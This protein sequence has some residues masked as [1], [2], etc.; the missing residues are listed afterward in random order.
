MIKKL[1]LLHS[2][3]NENFQTLSLEAIFNLVGGNG[4]DFFGG[5]SGGMMSGGAGRTMSHV[6]ELNPVKAN[7]RASNFLRGLAFSVFAQVA[8]AVINSLIHNEE[9]VF[10]SMTNYGNYVWYFIS[11]KHLNACK[12]LCFFL[13]FIFRMFI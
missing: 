6:T 5:G 10:I 1:S 7:P 11:I 12:F 2:H 8:I 3:N 9:D 4:A 13:S